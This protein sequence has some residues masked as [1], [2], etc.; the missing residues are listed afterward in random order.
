MGKSDGPT[1]RIKKPKLWKSDIDLEPGYRTFNKKAKQGHL[2][3]Y[4]Q[5]H[6]PNRMQ[7]QQVSEWTFSAITAEIDMLGLRDHSVEKSQC[8]SINLIIYQLTPLF[9]QIIPFS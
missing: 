8:D 1:A 9:T 4:P 6:C 2:R 3:F 5:T 7:V